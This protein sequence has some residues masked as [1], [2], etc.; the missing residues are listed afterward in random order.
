MLAP[1]L[2]SVLAML[3][4]AAP[5]FPPKILRAFKDETLFR[6]EEEAAWDAHH[7]RELTGIALHH[8]DVLKV[9]GLTRS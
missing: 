6:V 4:V 5:L 3:E 8:S 9:F 1:L 2:P 7:D